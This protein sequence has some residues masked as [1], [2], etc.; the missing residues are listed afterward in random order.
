MWPLFRRKSKNGFARLGVLEPLSDDAFDIFRVGFQTL[1]H[2]LL[3]LQ[4]RLCFPE[5]EPVGRLDLLQ[6]AIL[7]A[8]IEQDG[9][10]GRTE[11]RQ[12]NRI[13]DKDNTT[14]THAMT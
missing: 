13:K 6:L 5:L 14:R 4:T 3:L 7:R 2:Y 10:R 1:Q 8:R 9:P 12:D 11:S